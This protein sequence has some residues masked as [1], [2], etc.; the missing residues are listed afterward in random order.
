MAI[1][2]VERS[3]ARWIA[4]CLF[5]DR[6]V[7]KAAGFRWDPQNRCW[8]TTDAAIAAKLSDPAEAARLKAEAVAMEEKKAAAVAS[9]RAASSD[10][11]LPCPAGL[12]YLPYQ[13][14]GISEAVRRFSGIQNA[15]RR[16]PS[17]GVLLADEMGL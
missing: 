11:A 17:H 1:V 7:P 10:A 4:R 6:D 15:D 12:E 13:R 3:G 2:T 8:F 9:S 5:V 16:N 14:A